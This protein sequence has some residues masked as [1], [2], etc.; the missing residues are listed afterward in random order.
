MRKGG[1]AVRRSLWVDVEIPLPHVDRSE[2]LEAVELPPDL[3]LEAFRLAQESSGGGRIAEGFFAEDEGPDVLRERRPISPRGRNSSR[4]VAKGD[5]VDE[6]GELWPTMKHRID[7]KRHATVVFDIRI[8][9]VSEG[10]E[11][12]LEERVRDGLK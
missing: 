10:G 7:P 1:E 9:V 2:G 3:H 4:P 5:G 12:A 6:G 11:V 8:L